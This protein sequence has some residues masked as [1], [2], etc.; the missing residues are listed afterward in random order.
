M[1]NQQFVSIKKC[2]FVLR[3]KKSERPVPVYFLIRIGDTQIKQ[4]IG[5]KIFPSQWNHIKQRAY[6]S[7]I[8]TPLDNFN[9]QIVNERI[10][11][12]LTYYEKFCEYVNNNPKRDKEHYLQT[13]LLFLQEIDSMNGKSQRSRKTT[14]K[15]SSKNN[16]D[17][18]ICLKQYVYSMKGVAAGTKTN[19]LR[20]IKALE[21]FLTARQEKIK[22]FKQFSTEVFIE[23]GDWLQNNY[24]KPGTRQ[25][26]VGT[27]NDYLKCSSLLVRKC[28]V[29]VKELTYEEAEAIKYKA[30]TDKSQEDDIALTDDEVIKIFNYKCANDRDEKIKD[31]FLLECTSGLRISDVVNIDSNI[32]N[33]NGVFIVKILTKKSSGYVKCCLIFEMAKQILEKYKFVM[34]ILGKD[35]TA[36]KDTI[37][38]RIKFIA[39]DAGITGVEHKISHYAGND[40][41]TSVKVDRWKRVSTHTAR[42]TF[43]TILSLRGWNYVEIGKYTGQRDIR[44]VE[45]YDKSKG[46]PSAQAVF[47]ALPDNKRLVM[48]SQ[49]TNSV[50]PAV[51]QTVNPLSALS[52]DN[53]DMVKL[54]KFVYEQIKSFK[55]PLS[56]IDE[57]R[58]FIKSNNIS[59]EWFKSNSKEHVN[60]KFYRPKLE[61]IFGCDFVTIEQILFS[62]ITMKPD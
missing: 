31:M 20:A 29:S 10:G 36:I 47:N 7:K 1:A 45:R 8:L 23:M 48:I 53:N 58:H 41:P 33:E 50:V 32:N 51:T 9:N 57:T 60:Y 49:T 43:V 22:S 44:T 12:F 30:L 4:S 59:V 42:R 62:V 3:N 16:V 21:A 56:I 27:L 35:E 40:K 37:N 26:Q 25:L 18:V 15:N 52:G 2:G 39:R 34:P 11:L 5:A 19:Y 61:S 14:K 13:L 38:S 24:T 54:F 46:D 55:D 28:A 17:I 6:V